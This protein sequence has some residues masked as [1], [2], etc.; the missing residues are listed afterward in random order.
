MTEI[1][2][3]IRELQ[4]L[5]KMDLI[6]LLG[7][8]SEELESF[9]KNNRSKDVRINGLEQENESLRIEKSVLTEKNESLMNQVQAANKKLLEIEERPSSVQAIEAVAQKM[10]ELARQTGE[11]LSLLKEIRSERHKDTAGL[12][13]SARAEARDIIE[14]AQMRAVEIT[15]QL[16]QTNLEML[17][18][19]QAAI[20]QAQSGYEAAFETESERRGKCESNIRTFPPAGES[21]QAQKNQVV[22]SAQQARNLLKVLKRFGKPETAA[23][24]E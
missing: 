5:S 21:I 22:L 14:T 20:D 2:Q 3:E 13:G 11:Q 23:R 9:E 16:Q 15:K 6:I 12:A 7:E 17:V 18:N 8:L 4:K 24:G 1:N 19:M 10:S